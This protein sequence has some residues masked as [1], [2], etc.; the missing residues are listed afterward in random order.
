MFKKP[1]AELTDDERE[2]VDEIDLKCLTLLQCVLE[3]VEEV[4]QAAIWTSR[5][6]RSDISGSR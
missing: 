1:V 5:R 4:R 6:L 3:R 2:Q